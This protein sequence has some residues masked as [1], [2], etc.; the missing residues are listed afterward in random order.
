MSVLGGATKDVFVAG[1]AMLIMIMIMMMFM[2]IVS[3]GSTAPDLS[4]GEIVTA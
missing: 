1:Y 2:L 3:T 4:S